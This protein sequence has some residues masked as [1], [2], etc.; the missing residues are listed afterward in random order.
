LLLYCNKPKQKQVAK[1]TN[2]NN[3]ESLQ[4]CEQEQIH[5]A[6]SSKEQVNKNYHFSYSLKNH[7]W[8]SIN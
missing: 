6:Q 2:R 3:A 8:R 5:V 4:Q 7:F 1:E